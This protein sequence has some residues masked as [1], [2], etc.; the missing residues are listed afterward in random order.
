MKNRVDTRF[1]KALESIDQYV[2][3]IEREVRA[4][5]AVLVQRLTDI[6]NVRI[7]FGLSLLRAIVCHLMLHSFKVKQKVLNDQIE[8][9]SKASQDLKEVKH[10]FFHPLF[11]LCI[12]SKILIRF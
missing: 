11:F 4:R 2:S 8:E 5:K 9:L 3:N 1:H 12:S 6:T 7:L 10:L